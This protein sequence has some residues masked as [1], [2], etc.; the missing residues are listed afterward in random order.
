MALKNKIKDTVESAFDM[1]FKVTMDYHQQEPCFRVAPAYNHGDLFDVAVSFKNGIRLEMEF[2]P[3]P[4]SAQMVREMNTASLSK[5]KIFTD[6]TSEMK[7]KGA[8]VVFKVNGIKQSVSDYKS[9]PNEWSQISI[10][11]DVRPIRF[12]KHEKP[13]YLK[14][15][16]EWLPLMM[17]LSL[18]LLTV[19]DES[20]S[21]VSNQK[22]A[23]GRKYEISANRY[24]RSPINR[25]LCIAEYGYVC[26]V[27]GFDFE[28][29]YGSIG[30]RYIHV[31]HIIPVSQMG[32]GYMVDPVKDL[33]PVCPNCHAMLHRTD[34]PMEPKTLKDLI[35]K[36]SCK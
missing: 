1:P 23:E 9:W 27:C 17:G 3:Q 35:L 22:V 32:P 34:P 24:E 19:V 30:K 14:T 15:I 31:H 28:K 33:I 10:K 11:T 4:Y 25:T 29:T 2:V 13:D 36:N 16:E 21:D 6:Y 26:Q 5:R 12:D 18:S 7:R 8:K 20:N